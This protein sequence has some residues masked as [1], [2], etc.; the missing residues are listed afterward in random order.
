METHEARYREDLQ[1]T[2]NLI[3][4]FFESPEQFDAALDDVRRQLA[5]D[6]VEPD[7]SCILCRTKC[8]AEGL[9]RLRVWSYP[10]AFDS[11]KLPP[12]DNSAWWGLDRDHKRSMTSAECA[13][14]FREKRYEVL[15]LRVSKRDPWST[16]VKPSLASSSVASAAS[17]GSKGYLEVAS[18]VTSSGGMA[19]TRSRNR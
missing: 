11:L 18:T 6:H 3:V 17:S 15:E 19:A 4:A 5:R 14:F 7:R 16:G 12:E 8:G 9:P 1:N 13:A 2:R 10:V